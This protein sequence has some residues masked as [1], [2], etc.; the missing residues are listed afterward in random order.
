MRTKDLMNEARQAVAEASCCPKKLIAIHAGVS[1]AA[2]LVVA[3]LSYLLGT[4]I[5]DTG[6]LGGIGTRAALETAQSILEMAVSVLS[7]FWALG[8][9]AVALNMARRQESDTHTL[10]TGF[11]CWAPMLRLMLLEGVIVFGVVLL[12]MQVGSFL[13]M[14]T[15]F[16]NQ[17]N[18]LA[19]QI[20][21]TGATDTEALT[22]LLM[23]LDQETMMEIFWSIVPFMVLPAAA[24]LIP[25]S[26]R[27]RLAQYILLDQPQAGAM[28]A[29]LL[30][31]RLMK[32]QGWR[33]FG[34]DLR[35]W[36][37]YGLE[38]LV[39]ALCY[40]DL[41]LELAG[42]PLDG[43]G[44]LLS[45]LFYALALLCQVGLYVWKKP[46]VTTAYAL[47]YDR[48]L[49]REEAQEEVEEE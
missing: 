40:G 26:Y 28:F 13:Y 17:L 3:L 4:G 21:A 37:F 27:L 24:V 41:L 38:A 7:P 19:Q 25:L 8:F 6:G 43:N 14:L 39:L 35:L 29:L 49:P 44:V 47:F 32:K 9:M 20:A 2:A 15:P 33:L 1:A 30:S 16:S 36:W 46:Q 5:G 31:F 48:L 23:D 12:A 34:L 22:Q 11:R 18:E 10:L 45:F 42:V